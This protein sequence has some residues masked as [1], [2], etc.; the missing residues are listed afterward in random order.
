MSTSSFLLNKILKNWTQ[1]FLGDVQASFIDSNL[2]LEI[3]Y[4]GGT[5]NCSGLLETKV[6]FSGKMFGC[7]GELVT[8][9]VL[10]VVVVVLAALLVELTVMLGPGWTGDLD[11]FEARLSKLFLN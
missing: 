7:N 5:V 4:L 1:K 10:V 8:W 6:K 2:L 9:F 11:N 3:V